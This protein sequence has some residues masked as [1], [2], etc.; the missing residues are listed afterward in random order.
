MPRAL[1]PIVDAAL[2]QFP[3]VVVTGARPEIYYW[4]TA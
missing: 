2:E 3:M 1:G 4:R